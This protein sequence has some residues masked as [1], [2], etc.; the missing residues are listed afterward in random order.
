MFFYLVKNNYD[1]RIK[2]Y[3][4]ILFAIIE[5]LASAISV[6]SVIPLLSTMLEKNIVFNLWPFNIFLGEF[7]IN[8]K[9]VAIFVSFAMMLKIFVSLINTYLIASIK[10]S[11]WQSRAH[12]ITRSNLNLPY[13]VWINEDS[14][15]LISYLNR[16][17]SQAS[18]FVSGSIFMYI[19]L[20]SLMI[21]SITIILVSPKISLILI[22]LSILLYFLIF[23]KINLIS[24]NIGINGVKFAKN[25]AGTSA[26]II[27]A[28]KDFRLL[29]AVDYAVEKID[30]IIKKISNNDFKHYFLQAIPKNIFEFLIASVFLIWALSV[31]GKSDLSSGIPSLIFLI[32]ALT[33][34]ATNGASLST[35]YIKNKKRFSSFKL[36]NDIF[37]NEQLNSFQNSENLSST[38][39]KKNKLIIKKGFSFK[40]IDFFHGKNQILSNIC[41]DLPVNTVTILKGSS[42]AGKSTL[43]DIISRLYDDNSKNIFFDNIPS[44]SIDIKKWRNLIGYVSSNPVLFSTSIKNNIALNNDAVDANDIKRALK[45]SG[46]ESFVSNLDDNYHSIIIDRGR[47]LSAGQK[48]RLCIARVLVKNPSL[49]ILDESLDRL[50]EELAIDIIEDLKKIKN[51]TVLI[52]SHRKINTPNIFQTLT[53]ENKKIHTSLSRNNGIK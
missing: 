43:L 36:I 34:L 47:N 52:V 8:F 12:Y 51:L 48:F 38:N 28:G 50:E 40:N 45:L 31:T 30:K 37:F 16:E 9:V 44:D 5:S 2:F 17:L 32:T 41:F 20:F 49:L 29:N 26:E 11:F 19:Q 15:K 24:L 18:S 35:L 14:G 46:S 1:F 10:R 4:A 33:R 23:K 13:K 3:V 39:F 42:G 53:I 25:L 21:L 22:L 6:V 7:K 27:E